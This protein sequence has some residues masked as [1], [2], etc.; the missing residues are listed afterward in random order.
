MCFKTTQ[1]NKVFYTL[2]YKRYNE[3]DTMNNHLKLMI[4]GLALINLTA[5]NTYEEREYL[6]YQ[7]AFFGTGNLYPASDSY[8]MNDYAYDSQPGQGVVV[9]ESYHVG[10]F[11][12]PVSFKDRDRTWVNN[13]NAQGYTIELADDEQPSTVA[14][15]L[16]KAPK[17]DR[18][19]QIRYYKNGKTY[20]RGLYGSYENAEDAQKALNAL[21]PE[22]KK[23][24]GIKNWGSVQNN[25]T[26]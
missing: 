5:C 24:A 10:Q 19:A 20:Y 22:V 4:T 21:P 9:P 17:T 2:N 13:Q 15:Q 18:M 11:H 16:Y 14:Q 26:Q 1:V 12:S 25:L 7:P 6:T 23:N 8:R 3:G